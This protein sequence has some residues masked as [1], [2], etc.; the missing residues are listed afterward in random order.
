MIAPD[1]VDQAPQSAMAGEGPPTQNADHE[2]GVDGR[3]RSYELNPGHLSSPGTGMV[4]MV[5]MMVRETRHESCL[6][7]VCEE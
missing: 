2:A 3:K 5:E 4:M 6:I 7:R 1:L